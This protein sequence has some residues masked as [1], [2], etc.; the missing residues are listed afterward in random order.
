MPVTVTAILRFP[1]GKMHILMAIRLL[2]FQ[3]FRA[4]SL[5]LGSRGADFEKFLGGPERQL[6]LYVDIHVPVYMY[7]I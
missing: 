5:S 1:K 3:K 7:I 4:C 6:P 2:I